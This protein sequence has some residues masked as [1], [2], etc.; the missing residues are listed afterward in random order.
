M[1]KV[2]FILAF[3]VL[4]VHTHVSAQYTPPLIYGSKS[5]TP[6]KGGNE[7][8]TYAVIIRTDL[9][10]QA[11]VDSATLF[12]AHYGLVKKSDIHLDEI[13]EETSEYT[14]PITIPQ[15]MTTTRMMGMPIVI[16]PVMVDADLRFEFHDNGNVMIVFQ[17]FKNYIFQFVEK[18]E[19]R[20][21]TKF[22]KFEQ[23]PS[24][25]KY[26]EESSTLLTSSSLLVKGLAIVKG[27]IKFYNEYRAKV[28]E[29][30]ADIDS[31]YKVYGEL[32]KK[33]FAE[34]LTDEELI[35]YVDNTD[36]AGKKN[37]VKGY[38]KA[39]D[40]GKMLGV[41]QGRWEKQIRE[42]CD[43]LFKTITAGLSGSI[44]GVAEDG[45]QTWINIDGAV[46][47]VDPKWKDKTPPTDAKARE[48]YL[49]KHKN[50]Q[51]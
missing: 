30:F 1:K 17:N 18:G 6:I 7:G 20:V 25:E 5:I 8:K 19:Q 2:F 42:C 31:K 14:V 51:Y 41:G 9:S 49:K 11:L 32:V 27:G 43:L 4:A 34:W 44:E 15:T 24:H 10:K 13:N 48:K 22:D 45:E 36:F 21:M 29:Y 16:G 3:L 35:Q 47:P 37:T 39:Y 40:E 23:D 26:R 38:R 33:G 12:L 46:V 28:G 50:N